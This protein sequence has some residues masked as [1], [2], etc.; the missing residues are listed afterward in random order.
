MSESTSTVSDAALGHLVL[1]VL[2]GV[3]MAMHGLT[4]V[5]AP[6]AFAASMVKLFEPTPLPAVLVHAYALVLPFVELTVGLGLLAGWHLRAF[7]VLGG[8]TLVS[9][10]FGTCLRQDWNTAGTQLL[11]GFVFAW[12]LRHAREARFCVDSWRAAH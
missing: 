1:R 4:R 12:L 2:L 10:T 7:L 9:L 6:G 3:N 8:F 11:Y 5:G